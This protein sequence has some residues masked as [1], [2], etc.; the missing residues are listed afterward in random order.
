M[1]A[2]PL[3]HVMDGGRNERHV[4]YTSVELV[5]EVHLQC[6][7]KYAK[8]PQQLSKTHVNKGLTLLSVSSTCAS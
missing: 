7:V 2:L 1:L 6:T 4:P 8:R 5:H 3:S